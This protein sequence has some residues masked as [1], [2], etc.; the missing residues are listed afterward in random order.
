MSGQPFR[1]EMPE[2]PVVRL[3][4]IAFGIFIIGISIYELGR[5]VWPPNVTSPFF[6][7]LILGACT[8][9][10]ST[11]LGGLFGWSTTWDI[12][13]GVITI[14]L[15]NPFQRKVVSLKPSDVLDLRVV[16]RDSSEGENT[17][18]VQLTTSTDRF[19]TYDLSTRKAAEDLLGQVNRALGP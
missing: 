19:R 12:A 1:I 9:G 3:L 2:H 6:L 10:G 17:W 5:G 4:F 7:F 8:V 16:E 13:P 11:I 14:S 18:A 15:R